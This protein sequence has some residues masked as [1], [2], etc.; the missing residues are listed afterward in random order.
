MR[1]ESDAQPLSAPLLAACCTYT[2]NPCLLFDVA[3][4]LSSVAGACIAQLRYINLVREKD[5][6][7]FDLWPAVICAQ[8]VQCVSLTTAC[9]PYLQPFLMS[10]ESGFLRGDDFRRE[11]TKSSRYDRSGKLPRLTP[12]HH[13]LGNLA[14]QDY[15]IPASPKPARRG[16]WHGITPPSA[17]TILPAPSAGEGLREHVDIQQ[18]WD[19]RS[20]TS[21]VGLTN[22]GMPTEAT[23]DTR[24]RE[25]EGY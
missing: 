11:S 15:S 3:D 21:K 19:S 16:N 5:D 13:P 18:P 14:S 7:S 25:L 9:I 23:V 6:L 20:T 12:S 24:R 8:V 22:F 1:V 2:H 17:E 10:L 4:R